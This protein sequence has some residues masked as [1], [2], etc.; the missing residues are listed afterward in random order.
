MAMANE[1]QT[2]MRLDSTTM[3]MF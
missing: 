1:N 2:P 3:E